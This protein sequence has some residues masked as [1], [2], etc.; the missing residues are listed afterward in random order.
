MQR[1]P[2]RTTFCIAAA[3]AAFTFAACSDDSSGSSS[4]S[5]DT[6]AKSDATTTT[7]AAKTGSG[8][9]TFVLGD[10]TFT[11]DAAECTID[12]GDQPL[13]EA[14]GKGTFDNRPFTVTVRHSESDTS[15]IETVQVAFTATE[16]LVGTNFVPLPDGK[17][18]VKI[19]VAGK[20]KAEGTMPVTGTGGQPSGEGKLSL[21]CQG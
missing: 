18:S 3:L 9:G 10:R 21:D 17:D 4:S 2:L 16:A 6:T 19:T 8:T 11:F 7:E 12:D 1:S 14:S 5:S 13:V 20:G 15:A